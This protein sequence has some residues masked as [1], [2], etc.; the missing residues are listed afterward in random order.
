MAKRVTKSVKNEVGNRVSL[1]KGE[2]IRSDGMLMYRYMD[3]DGKR[4]T[5]YSS[6]IEGLREKEAQ[7]VVDGVKGLRSDGK[8]KTLDEVFTEWKEL[9]RGIRDHTMQNYSWVYTQ[10]AHGGFGKSRIKA[11]TP[12]DVR[13]F[14]N[15]LYDERGLAVSTIDNLQTVLRQVFDFA[16]QQR[17]IDI[18]PCTKAMVELRKA[19]CD[20]GQKHEALT[21]DEQKRL[22][23]FLRGHDTYKHWYPTFAVM[24]GTGMRVGELTGLRW[25]DIDFEKGTIDVSHT[26]VYYKDD[27]TKKMEFKISPPK[28]KAGRRTI[29]MLDFVRDALLEEKASQEATG[30]SCKAVVNG[31][32]NFV[33]VNRFGDV[34]HQGT[35]N[36]AL[37]RIIRDANYEAIDKGLTLLPPF[38]CHN[39]RA[40]FCT[41]LAEEGVPLKISMKLMGH[42][43]MRTT[44]AVYTSVCPDW[45][46]RELQ[47]VNNL[48]KN[49]HAS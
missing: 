44:M 24:V 41:R 22:L 12:A 49:F 37:R 28:S 2:S 6:T 30:A 15:G 47:S 9:K 25:C 34:Q 14:Y 17:Y 23:G 21:L 20:G 46:E 5:I 16:V 13:R 35:L 40:T 45:E 1:K 36:K 38:S 18:N 29:K 4:K 33:F 10:Y 8:T 39:L 32:T 48:F 26:L 43:D 42:D 7:I 11:L 27:S 31:Y 19:H 3:T